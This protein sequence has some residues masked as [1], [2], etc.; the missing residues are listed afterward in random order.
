[1]GETP[2][3]EMGLRR[4]LLK[5]GD[6]YPSRLRLRAPSWGAYPQIGAEGLPEVDQGGQYPAAI[7][8][9]NIIIV[10][11]EKE[12]LAVRQHVIAAAGI[13]VLGGGAIGAH[14]DNGQDDCG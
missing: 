13:G 12:V 8:V 5:I 10:V 11:V 6:H 4:I 7:A 1:M 14:D 9:P 3:I 2:K